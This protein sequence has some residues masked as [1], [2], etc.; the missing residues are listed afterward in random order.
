MV[1]VNVVA[2]AATTNATA[3]AAT[4][5]PLFYICKGLAFFCLRLVCPIER[6]TLSL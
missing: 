5:V 2:A 3:A 6:Q 1:L 4:D